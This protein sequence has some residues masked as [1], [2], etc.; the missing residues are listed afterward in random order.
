MIASLL[1]VAA[2]PFS[3][4]N[5]MSHALTK[6]GVLQARRKETLFV[7]VILTSNEVEAMLG[8]PGDKVVRSK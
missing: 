8:G 3:S 2:C 4:H 5:Y 6:R 1:K 7:L